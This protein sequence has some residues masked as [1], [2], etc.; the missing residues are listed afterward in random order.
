MERVDVTVIGGGVIGLAS[1][2]ALARNGRS[3]C[4]LERHSRPGM[5]TSTHNS[6]VIHAGLYYPSDSLKTRLCIDG[7]PLLYEYCKARGVP[8]Q[9]T[10]KLVLAERGEEAGLETL[11]ANATRNGVENIELVD[12]AFVHRREPNVRP[13][14][15]LFSPD[16]GIVESEALVRALAADCLDREVLMLPG[17]ELQ[18]GDRQRDTFRLHTEREIFE[19]RV[20]VNA[21]GL[22]ADDVSAKL[23]GEAFRIYPVRGEYASLVSSKRDYVRGLVYPMPAASGHSLGT[24]L[25]KSLNGD[26]LIG[27][28]AKYQERKDDYEENRRGLE[29][30]LAETQVL[31]PSV[32]LGDL[33]E[34]GSGIRP[35]LHPPE[36]PFADFMIRPDRIHP[37]LIHVAGIESPGLTA[38][39]AIAQVVATLVHQI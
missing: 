4:L 36:E 3:V 10:G 37:N 38:C 5:E 20:V 24:H 27:P 25:T 16:S 34:A 8:H 39:L 14:A 35:K 28:S 6:G 30:F 29:V 17:T 21:A 13:L 23:N 18:A 33:R 1:A 15:A 7:R 31:L 19:S 12:A 32:T 9:R 26:V 11:A 2:R 22:F